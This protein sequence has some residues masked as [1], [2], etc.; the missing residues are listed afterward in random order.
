ML[1]LLEDEV[2]NK[3]KWITHEEMLDLYAIGQTTPGVIMVNVATFIGYQRAGILGGIFA[4]TAVLTPSLIIVSLLVLFLQNFAD[5]L[6]VQ[7]A[8]IGINIAVAAMLC[9][10]VY[11]LWKQSVKGVSGGVVLLVSFLLVQ[12]WGFS[13]LVIIPGAA[14][15]GLIQWKVKQDAA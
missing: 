3:R 8:L 7:K 13:T 9:C 12:L 10:A 14:L 15:F 5:N 6:W 2:V 4:T 1:T 11:R